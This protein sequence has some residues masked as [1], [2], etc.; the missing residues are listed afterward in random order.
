MFQTASLEKTVEELEENFIHRK[1]D[2]L[3]RFVLRAVEKPLI[4]SALE[5]TEGNQLKAAK[6]LGINR[7]TLRSKMRKLGIEKCG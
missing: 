2:S 1:G 7:N 5:K 3:Y 4:E 6:F